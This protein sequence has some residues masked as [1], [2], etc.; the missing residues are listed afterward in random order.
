MLS[1]PAALRAQ[2]LTGT[3]PKG[4]IR[5][6]CFLSKR[7]LLCATALRPRSLTPAASFHSREACART[8]IFW[9]TVPAA[10]SA[11]ATRTAIMPNGRRFYAVN[12]GVR[13]YVS[14]G[15][16][17]GLIFLASGGNLNNTQGTITGYLV[18]L[19]N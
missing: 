15:V 11:Q 17:P 1:R 13:A 4:S 6:V 16:T 10:L 8:Q 3:L 9:F 7:L 12:S 19:N 18:N 2:T 5:R 14:A